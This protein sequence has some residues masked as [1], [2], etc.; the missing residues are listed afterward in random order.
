MFDLSKA[1]QVNA[2][3]GLSDS[4]FGKNKCYKTWVYFNVS[5]VFSVRI[6]FRLNFGE[7]VPYCV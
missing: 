4:K 5:K 2:K 6:I 1:V 7:N 3:L